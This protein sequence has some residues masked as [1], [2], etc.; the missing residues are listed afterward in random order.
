MRNPQLSQPRGRA[1]DKRDEL[2]PLHVTP[3]P[4]GWILALCGKSGHSPN[5]G[6]TSPAQP[7]VQAGTVYR[8]AVDVLRGHGAIDGTGNSGA[9]VGG[10]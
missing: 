4:D 3:R 8:R 2:A 6:K 7:L 9:R 10:C 5:H 1:A